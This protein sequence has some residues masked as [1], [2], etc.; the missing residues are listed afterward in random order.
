MYI[1]L[2]AKK[3]SGFVEGSEVYSGTYSFYDKKRISYEY[4]VRGNGKLRGYFVIGITPETNEIERKV[5]S[6]NE[7]EVIVPDKIE[8]NEY[9]ILK[10]LVEK[11]RSSL[12]HKQSEI[13]ITDISDTIQNQE[14]K[15][16]IS[17]L[18]VVLEKLNKLIC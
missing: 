14:I 9:T 6:E 17:D 2:I 12:L 3:G 10:S 16:S 13:T 8:M 1:I 11:E 18:D 5:L 15:N 7:V 4:Y